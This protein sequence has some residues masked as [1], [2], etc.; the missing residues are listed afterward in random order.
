VKKTIQLRD[1]F[2][3]YFVT[4]RLQDREGL[5]NAARNMNS[6]FQDAIMPS[7]QERCT[8]LWPLLSS[9]ERLLFLWTGS[10]AAGHVSSLMVSRAW[11]IDGS[12][13]DIS[14]HIPE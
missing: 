12:L 8:M 13:W 14:G 10:L 1:I 2:I 5:L 9:E 11:N 6:R 7:I 3:K 4:S